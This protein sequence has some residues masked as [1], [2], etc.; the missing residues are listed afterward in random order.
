MASTSV[1][2]SNDLALG[3]SAD[4]EFVHGP[5]VGGDLQVL[6]DFG[7]GL[8]DITSYVYELD[9]LTGR[10][11]PSQLQGKA[12]PG[13]LA[14]RLDNRDGR[15][16]YFNAD[17]PLNQ[18]GRTLD[19]G[20]TIRVQTAGTTDVDPVL[21]VHDRFDGTGPITTDE[22]GTAWEHQATGATFIRADG[23]V[24]IFSGTPAEARMVIDTGET[25]YYAQVTISETGDNV[26]ASGVLQ[27][28]N[29]TRLIYR[30]QDA[31][32]YS[33]L[34]HATADGLQVHTVSGVDVVAGT[35]STIFGPNALIG[36]GGAGV[37]AAGDHRRRVTIGAH[38]VGSSV[39]YYVNGAPLSTQT[40]IQTDET[41]VGVY[42]FYGVTNRSPSFDRFAVWDR[43]PTDV[44]GVLWTG[45]VVDVFPESNVGSPATATVTAEGALAVLAGIDI[46]PQAWAGR[47]RTGYPVGDALERAGLLY[48]PGIIAEGDAD[49]GSSSGA[50]INALTHCRKFEE[51]EIGF[52]H[53]APEGWIVYRDRSYRD[54]LDLVATFSD[55]PGAQYGYTALTL[56]NWRR[57]LINRV[58]AGVSY[59]AP[60]LV[61][62][63]G[64][65]NGGTASGV[66]RTIDLTMPSVGNISDG[67][68][69]VLLIVSTISS[70]TE[71]WV[72]PIFWVR[73]RDTGAS[74]SKRTQVYTHIAAASEAGNSVRFYNDAA[75]AGGSFITA[76]YQ[77]R[78]WYGNH[79]GIHIGDWARGE[80]FAG[81]DPSAILPPWGDT[82]ATCFIAQRGGVS[83]GAAGSVANST[84]PLGYLNGFSVFQN[85][86]GSDIH[87]CGMQV[88]SK[89][90][91]TALDDPSS[92]TGFSGLGAAETSVIAIRGR[93][94][95]PAE[96]RGRLRVSV[97]DVDS[98]RRHGVVAGYD[99]T[100]LFPTE[101]LASTW[102]DLMLTRYSKLRP[103]LR[104]SFIATTSA[105]YRQLAYQLRLS[106]KVHVTGTADSGQGI[107]GDFHVESIAHRVTNGMKLWTVTVQL[108]PAG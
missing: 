49:A 57:E 37:D 15:F 16:S 31:S 21:L 71:N 68:L 86:S 56:L 44:E 26:L 18:G 97:E 64:G 82:N 30:W 32:N 41:H 39:T 95:S 65:S 28:N 74:S 98:Q 63:G 72:T 2:G 35:P 79:E 75:A 40:A 1:F 51:V 27:Q 10:D 91:M 89:L 106:D 20:A 22:L 47:M 55:A 60:N 87:D 45:S 80:S 3:G 34:E 101:A 50:T 52:L 25:D 58:T 85:G 42:A 96:P 88:C 69:F 46:A 105:T 108:S 81:A 12:G 24:V 33:Y 9:L 38:V 84:Y 8:E 53:E 48:P 4:F 78:D 76:F 70:N 6:W 62:V 73:N 11:W 104:L 100:D 54:G 23:Q 7:Q 103:I 36:A 66:A 14:M 107:D 83:T 92:F 102:C 90:A 43:L 19:P 13:R 67:D 77:I 61:I 5:A 94:G 59:G 93:N 29:A 99:G 17:S